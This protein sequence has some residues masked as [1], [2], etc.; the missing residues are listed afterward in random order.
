MKIIPGDDKQGVAAIGGNLPKAC[1]L[2]AQQLEALR[3]NI[4]SSSAVGQT[5]ALPSCDVA[6]VGKGDIMS[7]AVG[8]GFEGQGRANFSQIPVSQ[9]PF[10]HPPR[11][12]RVPAFFFGF[13]ALHDPWGNTGIRSSTSS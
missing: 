2:L 7:S 5:T 10:F 13:A 11:S 9:L 12:E 3:I 8:K 4:L 6:R 1:L